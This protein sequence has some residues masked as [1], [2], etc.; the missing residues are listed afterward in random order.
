MATVITLI[1]IVWAFTHKPR[2]KPL[3]PVKVRHALPVTALPIMSPAEIAWRDKE[4]EKEVRE[5]EKERIKAEKERQKREQAEKDYSFYTS[6]LE[7]LYKQETDTARAYYKA[8]ET[9]NC[10]SEQNK[11]S[12]IVGEKSVAKHIQ[13][14]DR[15]QSKLL[16]VQSQIHGA[17]TKLSKAKQILNT[18]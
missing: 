9:V 17:E 1:V 13:E 4:R 3:R 10:D 14:R 5:A 2:K 12:Y 7:M 18:D 15:L 16:K 8:V 11:Y 6:R